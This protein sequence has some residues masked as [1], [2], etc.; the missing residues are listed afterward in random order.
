MVKYFSRILLVITGSAVLSNAQ[1]DQAG[2]VPRFESDVRPILAANCL[3]C[4]GSEM[5]QA[6]LDLRDRDSI[7]KGGRSGPAIQ[8]GLPESSLLLEKVI[9]GAMPP[10]KT[11]LSE[12]EID[13]IRRW[14]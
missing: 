8:R 6:G 3:I 1:T 5:Q 4:H 7:L 13:L 14:I 12:H 2:P 9:H 10:T 11:K